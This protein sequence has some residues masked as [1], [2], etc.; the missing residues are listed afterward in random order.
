[1]KK[2]DILKRII[3]IEKLLFELRLELETTDTEENHTTDDQLQVGDQVRIL[4]PRKD[5]PNTG[6]IIKLSNTSDYV[7]IKSSNGREL[8][9]IKK[10]LTKK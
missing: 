4:N 1:M 6:V 9:R 3:E 8:R 10:N 2:R 5:Q 7:T